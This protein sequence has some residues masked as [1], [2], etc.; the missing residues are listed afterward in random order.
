MKLLKKM[1][2]LRLRL[3]SSKNKLK[4]SQVFSLKQKAVMRFSRCHYLKTDQVKV[5][6]LSRKQ[7][8]LG[9]FPKRKSEN[10][11][12]EFIKYQV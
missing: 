8:K 12:S 3:K 7:R 4:A 11:S 9:N 1:S 2:P 6:A 5:D 10:L